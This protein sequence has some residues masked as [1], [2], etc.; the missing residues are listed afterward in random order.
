VTEKIFNALFVIFHFAVLAGLVVMLVRP[1]W[2][3][4]FTQ[5]CL[6][7]ATAIDLA[8]IRIVTC[9]ILLIY[10]LT[11]DLGSQAPFG[12]K[13]WSW[14]GY[15]EPLGHGWLRYFVTSKA[16]LDG[17]TYALILAIVLAM[18]GVLVRVT[19]PIT[20]VL[21]LMYGGLLRG[22][23]KY[24]HEGYLGLY[25]L[26]ALCFVACG[27]AWSVDAWW[28]KRRCKPAA[29]AAFPDTA[30][31]WMAWA[32]TAACVVP[33]VQL[34]FSKFAHGGLFWFDGRSLRNYMI[35]DELNL[36]GLPF[37]LA[38]HMIDAPTLM[39]TVMGFVGLIAEFTYVS[40]LFVP[41]MRRYLPP[42]IGL[43]HLGV[44]GWQNA[45]FIDAIL[46]PL[47][48]VR[49]SRWIRRPA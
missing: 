35:T 30:Y 22:F 21:Y 20:A 18:A 33:Y 19:L 28:R 39:F 40:V 36:R 10:V 4:W 8:Y 46:L 2:R 41:R 23:G 29:A 26:I 7:T 12:P 11:E 38:L 45:L 42:I 25:V 27:D 6:G 13:W 32:C 34:G 16:H 3:A 24:F 48:F 5:R 43:L 9:G 15:L 37:D 14:P 49:P 44:L 1:A 47:I 31:S 17:L